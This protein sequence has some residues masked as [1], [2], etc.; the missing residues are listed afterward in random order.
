MN[1]GNVVDILNSIGY[2]ELTELGDFYRTKPLY[3]SSKNN[4]SLSI[5]K[6]SGFWYDFGSNQFGKLEDLVKLTTG[7]NVFLKINKRKTKERIDARHLSNSDKQI[8]NHL[9]PEYKYWIKRGAKKEHL[10]KLKSGLFVHEGKFKNRY[11]FPIINY[12]GQLV[13]YSGR[14]IYSND[15]LEKLKI[16]KW[17]HIG[18]TS[19]WDYP[20]HFNQQRIKDAKSAILVESIGDM[21]ALFSCK[22][23]N[24]LVCFGLNVQNGVLKILLANKLESVILAFNNDDRRNGLLGAAK[25]KDKLHAYFDQET[26]K[27]YLPKEAN[28]FGEMNKNQ[29][30]KW[31]KTCQN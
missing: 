30:K 23:Y 26:V 17:K 31:Y 21:L 1:D 8:K 13:G 7:K 24:V 4:T 27:V 5:N 10:R 29:I 18:N 9:K 28:D 11:V 14:S 16:P 2:D 22:I 19:Q 20:Y 12:H 3:R 25:A 15:F 6:E